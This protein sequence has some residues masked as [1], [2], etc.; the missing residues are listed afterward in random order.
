MQCCIKGLVMLTDKRKCFSRYYWL[1][2]LI[3]WQHKKV[4]HMLHVMVSS[5]HLLKWCHLF[6]I[7]SWGTVKITYKIYSSC[8]FCCLHFASLFSCLHHN[9]IQNLTLGERVLSCSIFLHACQR[10]EQ[11]RIITSFYQTDHINYNN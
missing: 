5:L 2:C 10:N 4:C 6:K 8:T 3:Q 1:Q 7:F 9:I 11:L